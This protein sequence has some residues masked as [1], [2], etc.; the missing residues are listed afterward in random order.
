MSDTKFTPGPW[1]A[2]QSCV[3][4]ASGEIVTSCVT[5]SVKR[6]NDAEDYATAHLI[7]AAPELYEALDNLCQ[8]FSVVGHDDYR[9][10]L[11]AAEAALAKARGK[12]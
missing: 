6:G 8:L 2:K 11:Y 12:S 10:E 5:G 4:S 3:I 7:A 1:L 9:A